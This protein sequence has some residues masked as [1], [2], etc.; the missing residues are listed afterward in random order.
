MKMVSS[1]V[2][3]MFFHEFIDFKGKLPALFDKENQT[4]RMAA[5]PD[6]QVVTLENSIGEESP[7]TAG[8]GAW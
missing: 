2:N 3:E 1:Q 6:S 7:S 5:L 8:Q 4:G